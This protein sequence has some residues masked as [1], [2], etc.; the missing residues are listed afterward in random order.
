VWSAIS[1]A[2]WVVVPAG[3]HRGDDRVS[4]TVSQNATGAPR[5]ATIVVRDQVVQ[6][7]QN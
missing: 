6:I 5:T 7:T 3:T 4:F 1:N 2:D